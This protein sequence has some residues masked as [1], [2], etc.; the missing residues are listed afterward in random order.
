MNVRHRA[1]AGALLAL[2][3]LPGTGH[4]DPFVGRAGGTS[5]TIRLRGS[6]GKVY[7]VSFEMTSLAPQGGSPSYTLAIGIQKCDDGACSA[8]KRY[9]TRL[10]AAQIH[11]DAELT[12]VDV[13]LTALGAPL[14]VVWTASQQP[15]PD[16]SGVQVTGD[17]LNVAFN[18][19]D[20]G[21]SVR[22]TLWGVTCRA[23][24]TYHNPYTVAPNGYTTDSGSAP[25]RTAPAQFVK[26]GRR[27]PSCLL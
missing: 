24:G 11:A 25:P 3:L 8:G 20:H 19:S 7:S 14:Q 13:H 18:N 12:S 26:H 17:V 27:V 6:D 1:V 9:V 10:S 21:A 23:D 4:A 16:Q 5:S 2:A 22:A 15:T